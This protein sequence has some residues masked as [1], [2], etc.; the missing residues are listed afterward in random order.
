MPNS[1]AQARAV[2]GSR[3]ARAWRAPVR[4]AR[5]PG[6]QA[7]RVIRAQP[8]MPQRMVGPTVHFGAGIGFQSS[9]L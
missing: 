3:L 8:R 7:R 1:S 2:A 6:H 9:F 4:E 5:M